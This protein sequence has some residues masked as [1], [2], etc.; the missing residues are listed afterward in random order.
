ME[1][2]LKNASG[3]EVIKEDIYEVF[4]EFSA[5]NQ[6]IFQQTYDDFLA[7][8]KRYGEF[9]NR[10]NLRNL[11]YDMVELEEKFIDF[12]ILL[13]F[14]QV[15][16]HVPVEYIA[17]FYYVKCKNPETDLSLYSAEEL[18]LLFAGSESL[19]LAAIDELIVE[20]GYI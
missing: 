9:C 7:E 6:V 13:K 8:R 15:K 10:L 5:E 20:W 16:F 2:L 1:S 11:N 19:V 4:T 12:L 18:A 14:R 3:T 17:A